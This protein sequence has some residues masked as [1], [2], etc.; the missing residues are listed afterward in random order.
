MAEVVA[1]DEVGVE[2]VV[3]EDEVGVEAVVED[4]C[5]DLDVVIM[6]DGIDSL[7]C[8]VIGMLGLVGLL[9]G[10]YRVIVSEVVP[11][12]DVLFLEQD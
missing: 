4:I 12:R 10:L 2:E 11:R 6:E 8:G 9:I 3:A 5:T 1:E 7:Y